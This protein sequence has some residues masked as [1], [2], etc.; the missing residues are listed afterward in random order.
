MLSSKER[1]GTSRRRPGSATPALVPN[2]ETWLDFTDLVFIDPVGT[3]YSR[4]TASGDNVRRQFWSVDGDANALAVTIRKW[5]E[6]AGRQN[7]VKFVVGESYGGFRVP[8]I[9]VFAEA[10]LCTVEFLLDEAVAVKIIG[11]LEGEE[12]GHTHH[13]GAENF[14]ADRSSSA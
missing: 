5:I 2:A 6:H 4:I 9:V 14:I 11:G 13:H 12:G 10:D 8:K 1:L 7:S 3:G